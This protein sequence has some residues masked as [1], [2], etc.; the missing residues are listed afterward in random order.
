VAEEV[1]EEESEVVVVATVEL[2]SVQVR[3]SN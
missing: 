3:I 2:A 1:A